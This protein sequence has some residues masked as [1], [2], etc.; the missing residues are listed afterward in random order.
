M[1]VRFLKN[2][3]FILFLSCIFAA[4]L[5]FYSFFVRDQKVLG[6][7]VS[8]EKT[9][10]FESTF[11]PTL[12]AASSKPTP[13]PSPTPELPKSTYTIA[14]FGDSMI[15]TMGENLDYLSKDLISIYP[16]VDFKLYNYG[17][18][19]QNIEQGIARWGNPF[20]YQTRN[21]PPITQIKPDVII[22]GSFAYSPFPQHDLNRYLLDLKELVSQAKLLTGN[23][24]L[25]AEIAPL[26]TGFGKGQGGPNWPQDLADQQA[27]RIVEQLQNVSGVA[28]A[29]K[30]N[31]IDAYTQ[32]LLDD[33]FGSPVYVNSYDGI[34]PSVQGHVM[35]ANLIARAIKLR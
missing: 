8:E 35:V 32:S 7:K 13:T 19:A 34:H 26:K 20:S 23:I 18:G 25:L 31:L 2:P 3:K 12:V 29:E 21:Y 28:K 17:I 9:T 33:K 10:A 6:K 1:L 15:D 16:N 27:S 14:L 30:V 4:S 11:S 22:L 5:V 24:Y